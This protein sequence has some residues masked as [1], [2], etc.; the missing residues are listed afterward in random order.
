MPTI[1]HR[2]E[3]P[4]RGILQKTSEMIV[5]GLLLDLQLDE[6][7]QNAIYIGSNFTAYSDYTDENGAP[8]LV[9]NRCDVKAEYVLDKAQVPWPVDSRYNTTAMGRRA[10]QAGT[11]PLVLI[12]KDASIIIEYLTIASAIELDFDLIFQSYDDAVRALDT[13]QSKFRGS[14]VKA[15]FDIPVA[16]PVS[17]SLMEFLVAVWKRKSDYA[18]KKFIEYINDKKITQIS[19]DVRKTQLAETNPDV[20]LKIR[21]IASDC[22]LQVTMD[23]KEPEPEKIDQLADSFHVRFTASLQYPRP[24]AIIVN[25]PVSVDNQL[26]P[27]ELFSSVDV[28]NHYN[29]AAN[30]IWE[31][32]FLQQAT[33]HSNIGRKEFS[34]M[35]RVPYYD[36]WYVN[37]PSYN[38]FGYK[39]LATIHF[40]LDGPTT[41]IDLNNLGDI[42]LHPVALDILKQAGPN[43]LDLGSLLYV[44]IYADDVIM[45]GDTVSMDNNGIITVNSNR[46]DKT[47][48]LMI[49]ETTDIQHANAIWNDLLLKYRYFFPMTIM[50]NVSYLIK[51]G[52][53]VIGVSNDFFNVMTKLASNG[54]LRA[55]VDEMVNNGDCTNEIY[56]FGMTSDQLISYLN[57]HSSLNENYTLPIDNSDESIRLRQYYGTIASVYS[58]SLTTVL[59]GLAVAHGD[60]DISEVPSTTFGPNRTIYPLYNSDGGYY[61]YNAPFRVL[62]GTI[63]R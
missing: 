39:P 17:F 32:I 44:S 36:D 28:V 45:S 24:V 18:N 52:Y 6:Y 34:P 12:D 51:R 31:N 53:F 27:S 57:N 59:F 26:L 37:D 3:A 48:H 61:G 25:T 8:N 23:M 42:A 55:L 21:T 5:N 56:A 49:S 11:H 4:S 29:P 43:A 54:R 47:Y 38:S 19:F 13:I 35:V 40:T 15:P 20:E 7:M 9:R 50:R 41:T 62:N 58:R 10:D 16:F 46:P 63:S 22:P 2:V 60:I 14:M 33:D 30:L 1:Y